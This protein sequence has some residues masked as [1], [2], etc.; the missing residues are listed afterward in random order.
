MNEEEI[1]NWVSTKNQINDKIEHIRRCFYRW[2]CIKNTSAQISN[3]LALMIHTKLNND[4]LVGG[5]HFDLP[6]DILTKTNDEID[7]EIKIVVDKIIE[8]FKK[9]HNSMKKK[10]LQ[11]QKI[12]LSASIAQL[13]SEINTIDKTI[14]ELDA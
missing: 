4:D 13:T 9:R 3:G 11:K 7:N 1:I 12:E 6:L 2:G 8:N 14:E 5:E 10:Q